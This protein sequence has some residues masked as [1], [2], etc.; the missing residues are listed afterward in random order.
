MI[1]TSGTTWSRNRSNLFKKWL[2][3][4]PSIFCQSLFTSVYKNVG[5]EFH[6]TGECRRM[7]V[8]DVGVMLGKKCWRM[9]RSC[10][11]F[12]S[13]VSASLWMG[14]STSRGCTFRVHLASHRG[15]TLVELKCWC[16]AF[17]QSNKQPSTRPKNFHCLAEVHFCHLFFNVDSLPFFVTFFSLNHFFFQH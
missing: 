8:R 11:L 3:T 2:N 6:S 7:T 13:Q 10:S 9:L 16:Q 1:S 5:H 15:C 17:S 12:E 4:M 14:V